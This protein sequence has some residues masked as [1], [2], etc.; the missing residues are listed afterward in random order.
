VPGC[1]SD[2]CRMQNQNFANAI[3]SSNRRSG[4]QPNATIIG[5]VPAPIRAGKIA[6]RR[7]EWKRSGLRERACPSPVVF[8]LFSGLFQCETTEPA[9]R[10]NRSAE[11]N[12]PNITRENPK[13]LHNQTQLN[14]SPAEENY[15]RTLRLKGSECCRPSQ[16]EIKG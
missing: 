12:N 13:T 16:P 11:T 5:K 3:K 4:C 6:K 15:L 14:G 9:E 8:S 7:N 1:E 2:H 10:L